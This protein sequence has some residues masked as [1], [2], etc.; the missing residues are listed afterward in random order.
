MAR[1]AR[2]NALASAGSAASGRHQG[3]GPPPQPG[4]LVSGMRHRTLAPADDTPPRAASL[5]RAR[6]LARPRHGQSRPRRDSRRSHRMRTFEKRQVVPQPLFCC[7]R[8]RGT[9]GCPPSAPVWSQATL[10]LL[11]G[12]TDRWTDPTWRRRRRRARR[13]R[14]CGPD[15]RRPLGQ[16]PWRTSRRWVAPARRG[17][18][19]VRGRHADQSQVE[20]HSKRSALATGVHKHAA[21]WRWPRR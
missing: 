17:A 14:Q 3:R 13:S 16:T 11:P 6:I 10:T 4:I 7:A 21:R 2:H 12:E 19:C 15:I 5:T 1:A 8:Q 9:S 20:S 18:S